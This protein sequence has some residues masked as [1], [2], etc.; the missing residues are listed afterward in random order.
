[1]NEEIFGGL[2]FPTEKAIVKRGMKVEGWA[3]SNNNDE[4]EIEPS[5]CSIYYYDWVKK[6]GNKTCLE[7]SLTL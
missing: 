5:R 3:L 7:K 1:M 2:D 4:V 6:T